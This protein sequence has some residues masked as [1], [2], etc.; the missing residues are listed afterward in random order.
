MATRSF[1]REIRIT[2]TEAVKKFIEAMESNSID[3]FKTPIKNINMKDK[4]HRELAKRI[5]SKF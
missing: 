5:T 3:K 1:T 2:N 4:S